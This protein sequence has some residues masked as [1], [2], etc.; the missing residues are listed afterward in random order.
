LKNGGKVAVQEPAPSELKN[1][2][3]S[4][5]S[6]QSEPQTPAVTKGKSDRPPGTVLF[7][8][9]PQKGGKV[10]DF[11][12]YYNDCLTAGFKIVLSDIETQIQQL[13]VLP[14][15][16]TADKI[17][18][19]TDFRHVLFLRYANVVE[20]GHLTIPLLVDKVK[21]EDKKYEDVK[22][23]K[24]P[25]ADKPLEHLRRKFGST[26]V[27]LAIASTVCSTFEK[28]YN[29]GIVPSEKERAPIFRKL[30]EVLKG[31]TTEIEQS[32]LQALTG[33]KP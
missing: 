33:R 7:T 6:A 19:L 28:A 25:I 11:K 17:K 22:L 21:Q 16:G 31:N 8:Q 13:T 20:N 26:A 10:V 14:G 27:P 9:G 29:E 4:Q 3:T 24:L 12:D 15:E 2:G 32:E 30:K 1:A 23:A 18:L 5:A